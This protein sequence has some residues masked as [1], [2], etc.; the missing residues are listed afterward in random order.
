MEELESLFFILVILF[1]EDFLNFFLN[2]DNLEIYDSEIS[3][4]NSFKNLNNIS[5]IL[6]S[7]SSSS[8]LFFNPL[9]KDKIILIISYIILFLFKLVSLKM[10][11]IINSFVLSNMTLKYSFLVLT[12]P[13]GDVCSS[14][15]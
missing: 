3:F 10:I 5:L 4:K 6:I 9:L 12:S 11:S 2:E 13:L 15:K 7:S 8:L 14:K 1:D